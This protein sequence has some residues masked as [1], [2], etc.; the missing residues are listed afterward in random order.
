MG[1][2][3]IAIL[4]IAVGLARLASSQP[5]MNHAAVRNQVRLIQK[6]LRA[7]LSYSHLC[8]YPKPPFYAVRYE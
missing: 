2:P 1:L 6:P 7:S 3:Q 8:A 4:Q 5:L